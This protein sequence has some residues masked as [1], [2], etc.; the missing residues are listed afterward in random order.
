M[1]LTDRGSP[2]VAKNTREQ[3]NISNKRFKLKSVKARVPGFN[4]DAIICHK[5]DLGRI[6]L[7][8]KNQSVSKNSSKYG[9]PV[10]LF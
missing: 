8:M 1:S 10:F 6:D 4:D 2:K 3:K 7:Q 9:Y 5:F